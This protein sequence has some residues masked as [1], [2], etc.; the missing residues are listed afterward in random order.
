VGRE[1]PNRFI[2]QILPNTKLHQQ[3]LQLGRCQKGLAIQ[4]RT[5]ALLNCP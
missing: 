3:L 2:E 4:S 1:Y 5:S